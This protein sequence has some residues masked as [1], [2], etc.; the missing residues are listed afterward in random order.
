MTSLHDDLLYRLHMPNDATSDSVAI[1]VSGL[2]SDGN[3]NEGLVRECKIARLSNNERE[4]NLLLLYDK[5]SRPQRNIKARI[6]VKA[7]RA[8]GV[9]MAL[10]SV[11]MMTKNYVSRSH[12]TV[13]SE[14]IDWAAQAREVMAAT[15]QGCRVRSDRKRFGDRPGWPS[16]G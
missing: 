4:N 5:L 6:S 11:V 9:P 1:V 14:S 13:R 2:F 12:W 3:L 15:V 10:S 8:V 16:S 7:T